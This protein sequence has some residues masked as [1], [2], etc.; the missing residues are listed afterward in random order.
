MCTPSA[1]VALEPLE[2]TEGA[3]LTELQHGPYR[4][5]QRVVLRHSFRS[6]LATDI[7]HSL[8]VGVARGAPSDVFGV[9]LSVRMAT[10]LQ[11]RPDLRALVD[12]EKVNAVA[13]KKANRKRSNDDVHEAVLPPATR[14]K[15]S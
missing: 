11:Q 1:A 4:H 7:V 5:A 14:P 12:E 2:Q 9:D 15:V 8:D 3:A 10:K 13:A 6:Q